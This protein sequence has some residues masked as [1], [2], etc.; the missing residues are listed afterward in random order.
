M[1]TLSPETRVRIEAL[2]HPADVGAVQELLEREC[3]DNLPFCQGCSPEGLERV[4]FAVLKLSQGSLA[5]LQHEVRG[6]K[7]DWR[8]TLMA[9]GFGLD[10][11]A[12]RRWI[13]ESRK[14]NWTKDCA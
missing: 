9:A 8:D 5:R 2:F 11:E 10:A 6:A 13:P 14:V 4:R 3:A 7:L 12:H 1:V